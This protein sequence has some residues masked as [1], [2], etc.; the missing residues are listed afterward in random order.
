MGHRPLDFIKNELV[1]LPVSGPELA[2]KPIGRFIAP[3]QEKIIKTCLDA[4]G[5]NKQN[6]FLGFS[7][8]IGKSMIFS[9]LYS[10]FLENKEGFQMVSMAST[11]MQS[12]HIF[13]LLRR[14]IE[15]NPNIN[16]ADYKLTREKIINKKRD[17]A[18][19]R[20][21]SEAGA[22]LGMLNISAVICDQIESMQTRANI[23]AIV[24]G[25]IMSQSKP[26]YLM[27]ANCPEKMSHWSI[28][29]LKTKKKDPR[30]SFFKY[31]APLNKPW[32]SFEAKQTANP[33][34]KLFQED[35]EKYKH[36][37]TL[38]ENIDAEEKAAVDS[39]EDSLSYRKYILGQ[40]IS[41]RVYQWIESKKLKEAKLKDFKG[42]RAVLS[43]DIALV[44]DFCG[45]CVAFFK[46]NKIGIR[47]FLHVANVDWRRKRQQFLFRQWA[48]KGWI[49]IQ[50][51]KAIDKTVF[52]GEVKNWLSENRIRIDKHVWDR[53][54]CSVEWTKEFHGEPELVR[55][56]PQ[57]MAGGIRHLEAASHSG[58]LF[59]I[60]G[61]DAVKAQF[62]SAVA[63]AKSKSFVSLDRLSDRESIEIPICAVMATKWNLENKINDFPIM[64]I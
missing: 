14:Q 33:F 27:A 13:D 32:N 44:R 37:K 31:Q 26:L 30:F 19:H 45:A 20:I 18:V 43:I 34:Y 8:K 59:L 4:E 61:N 64:A 22:N 1:F 56:S 35:N 6:I 11:F 16:T 41:S 57:N 17:N 9:W 50:D 51:Q 63:S 15:L 36:L 7:R 48:D 29:Y 5:N 24:T 25:M 2:G 58:N 53:G 39:S 62:D 38:C 3:F 10:Y 47:S 49:T 46:G 23:D 12:G 55:G 60:D 54:L 28:D 21:Y 42:S 40:L 52:L